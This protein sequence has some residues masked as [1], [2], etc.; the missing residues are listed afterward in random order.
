MSFRLIVSE[1]VDLTTIRVAGLLRDDAVTV[2][3][4]ACAGAGRPLVLDLSDLTSASEAGVLL[5]RRLAGEG[6]HVL[7]E[8]HYMRLLLERAVSVPGCVRAT[9]PAPPSATKAPVAH[10]PRRGGP[11]P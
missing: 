4:D 8:S 3:G 1:A 10:R 11:R 2:L 5:L 7:G 9:T 6:I